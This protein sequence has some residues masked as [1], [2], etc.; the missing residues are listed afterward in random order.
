MR[1]DYPLAHHVRFVTQLLARPAEIVRSYDRS[2]L[3]AD[4]V[5]GLTVAVVMLPQAMG[6]ALIAGLPVRAGLYAAI[7]GSIFGALWGSSNQ[8]QTGPTN[9]IS[10]LVLSTLLGVADPGSP[11]YLAAAGLVA[12]MVGGFHLMMGFARLGVLVNFVSH[13]MVVGFSA[14]AGILIAFHQAGDLLR[15]AVPASP[16]LWQTIPNIVSHL[17]QT[18]APSLALGVGTLLII[19]LSR[20]IDR[21]IPGLLVGMV[22]AASVVG[23]L[24]LEAQGIEVAGALPRRLPPLAD[25]SLI[26]R[27]LALNLFTGSLAVA[28]I[29]LV[30]AVSIARTIS[31]QTGQRLD[32]NQEFVGQGLANIASGIFSGYVC[33]GSFTRSALNHRGGARTQLSSV[34]AGLFVLAG[35]ILLA[36]LAA[37]V[38][39][40]ALAGALIF[41]G[42]NLIDREEIVRI[43]QANPGDRTIMVVTMA[44]TLLT[45]LRIAVIVG[46]GSSLLYYLLKTTA[47]RVRE[48][49]MDDDY[50]Y[51]TPR[52]EQPACPQLGVVEILGDLYFGAVSHIEERIE[53]LRAEHPGQRFLLLRMYTV[54]NCD[55]SGIHALESIVRSYRDRGGDVYFVHVQK[56][57]LDLMKS[58]QFYEYVGGDHFLHP[59]HDIDYL[60]HRVIDP[61]I[62]IYECPVRAF[63]YC[64][65]LPKQLYEAEVEWPDGMDLDQVP[66]MDPKDLWQTLRG[67]EP[68]LVVDVREPREYERAHIPEARLIRLPELLEDPQIPR[69]RP[70]VL[71]CRGGRRSARAA[72]VLRQRGFDNIRV[73]HGGTR[74][75]ERE[76]LL[77]A[78][79]YGQT[80]E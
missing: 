21:R 54:E 61:A 80:N 71:V 73:L 26:D 20:G 8:L 62:C 59:D 27:E 49:K 47:P 18:H 29:G 67:D 1:D 33:A 51:F 19:L 36:P 42:L 74:A 48:V 79:T 40:A 4:L 68:P 66:R 5:A 24:G 22:G 2:Y 69:D 78:V 10:L 76:N 39:L 65:N 9:T 52:P 63:G 75:W 32:S 41:T 58:S 34:F 23:L 7:V 15:I 70:V 57:V 45:P 55:I 17:P 56:P 12:V 50:R 44:A 28:A 25:F 16:S 77:E 46:I 53:T 6:Y 14:G 30:E 31:T 43:W 13:S 35:V 37:Y 3:R 60:F 11:R 38:P 72:A 64:Q